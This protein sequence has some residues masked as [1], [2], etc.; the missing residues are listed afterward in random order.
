MEVQLIGEG[1]VVIYLE[2]EDM[3][4]LPDPPQNITTTQAAR[5]LRSALG[6]TYDQ[7]WERVCFEL[8]PG[9]DSMLLFALQHSD[10]PSYF[11]FTDIE[12]VI[13]A[14]QACPPGIISYLT[15]MDDSYILIVYPINGEYPPYVLCEY[16]TAISRPSSFSVYLFEHGKLIAGPYALDKICRAFK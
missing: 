12:P 7:S 9:R 6:D 11:M 13:S 1:K 5:L 16:G 4:K 3:K 8:Y 10:N 15:Y 14:A 2:E